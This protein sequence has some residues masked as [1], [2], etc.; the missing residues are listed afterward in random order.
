MERGIGRCDREPQL[1]VLLGDGIP[2]QVKPPA[3]TAA[4]A[5]VCAAGL[6]TDRMSL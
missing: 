4:P 2:G 3:N 5:A 1:S 6:A